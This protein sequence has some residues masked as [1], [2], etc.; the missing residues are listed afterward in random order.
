MAYIAQYG[1]ME[2]VGSRCICSFKVAR[3]RL[4]GRGS[5]EGKVLKG[6]YENTPASFDTLSSDANVFSNLYFLVI[7]IS[8][9]LF[10]WK[11]C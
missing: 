6:S 5:L 4:Q 2:V 10:S 9:F 3:S 11:Y 7:T 8:F 1:T